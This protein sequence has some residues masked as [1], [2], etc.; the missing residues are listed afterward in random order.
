MAEQLKSPPADPEQRPVAVRPA[1]PRDA[2]LLYR[3]RSEPSVRRYQPLNRLSVDQLRSEL[4]S[5]NLQD[6]HRGRIDKFQ[7]IIEAPRPSGWV[8]LV[9]A[10]WEH[11][12]AEIGYA[13]GTVHQRRGIMVSALGTLLDEL[14]SQTRLRRIEARCAVDNYPSQRV[15]ERL[16]FVREGRLRGFFVLRGRPVDNYLYAVLDTDWGGR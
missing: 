2:Q 14:F 4:A 13:L 7:W 12:L 15:L 3:W 1:Y 9:V 8:T 5:Q 11:G 16:G 6:L 10:N